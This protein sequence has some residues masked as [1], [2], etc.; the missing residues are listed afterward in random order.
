MGEDKATW[1]VRR[2]H[3]SGTLRAAPAVAGRVDQADRSRLAV[4]Q[5]PEV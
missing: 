1:A 3:F 5:T 4:A 2:F